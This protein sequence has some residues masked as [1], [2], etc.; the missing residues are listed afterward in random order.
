MLI[1][2]KLKQEN[3]QGKQSHHY[4]VSTHCGS[5]KFKLHIRLQVDLNL[6]ISSF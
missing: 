3:N 4:N 6:D 1:K 5:E 2:E